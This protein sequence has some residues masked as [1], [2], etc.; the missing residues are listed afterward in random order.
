MTLEDH[1]DQELYSR[2]NTNKF[3]HLNWW[4][5]TTNTVERARD[6]SQLVM[7]IMEI[8]KHPTGGCVKNVIRNT[9]QSG[10]NQNSILY[11]IF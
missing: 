10:T 3:L 2:L 4:V 5:S 9:L 7:E 8:N 1:R 6:G 11:P